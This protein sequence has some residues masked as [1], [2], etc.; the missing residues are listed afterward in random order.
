[1]WLLSLALAAPDEAPLW[2]PRLR[3]WFVERFAPDAR[4]RW[5][6][7][8]PTES[9]AWRDTTRWG[10]DTIDHPLSC[11]ESLSR[12]DFGPEENGYS[13]AELA[14]ARGELG[15][16]WASAPTGF[17]GWAFTASFRRHPG[18]A[19]LGPHL[20]VQVTRVP[21]GLDLRRMFLAGIAQ[22]CGPAKASYA[23][24][25]SGD[26]L[27]RL[28][29]PCSEHTNFARWTGMIADALPGWTGR[30]TDD[31]LVYGECGTIKVEW[32][33]RAGL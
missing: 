16:G 18:A 26:L 11:A 12:L 17:D 24:L 32:R 30:P 2:E 20:A 33:E 31:P 8:R 25:W 6:G 21:P 4:A 1:M 5:S 10:P 15:P 19:A 14:A 28:D 3:A 22:G 23:F 13:E 27:V 29:S 9:Y 7:A